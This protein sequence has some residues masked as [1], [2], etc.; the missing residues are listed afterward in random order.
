MSKVHCRFLKG[1]LLSF[2]NPLTGYYRYLRKASEHHFLYGDCNDLS[3]FINT[4][5]YSTIISIVDDI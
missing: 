4:D 3:E 5:Y 1:Y 2:I